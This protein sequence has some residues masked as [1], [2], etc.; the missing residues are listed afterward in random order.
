MSDLRHDKQELEAAISDLKRDKTEA[1]AAH[2]SVIFCL[3]MDD[4]LT[5]TRMRTHTP[6]TLT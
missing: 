2:Q 1:A 4:S 5:R 6:S 3:R